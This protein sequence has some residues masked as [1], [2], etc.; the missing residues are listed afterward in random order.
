M[1]KLSRCK[2]LSAKKRTPGTS[3]TNYEQNLDWNILVRTPSNPKQ[4]CI[5]HVAS[6]VP[7]PRHDLF[8]TAIGLPPTFTPLQPPLAVLKAVRPGSPK[9]VVSGIWNARS[10]IMNAH[11]LWVALGVSRVREPSQRRVRRGGSCSGLWWRSNRRPIGAW[12]EGLD[13]SVLY[14]L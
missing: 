2:K 9:Q 13:G 10:N 5:H 6:C 12:I 8:E 4:M 14:S 3:G 11:L 7:Y 1:S